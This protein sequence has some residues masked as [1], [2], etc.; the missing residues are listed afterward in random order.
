MDERLIRIKRKNLEENIEIIRKKVKN[1]AE[2]IDK[3][4][5]NE[6]LERQ[7]DQIVHRLMWGYANLGLDAIVRDVA[8]YQKEVGIAEGIEKEPGDEDIE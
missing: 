6:S 8:E 5:K 1:M 2:Q 3:I 4:T 7:P